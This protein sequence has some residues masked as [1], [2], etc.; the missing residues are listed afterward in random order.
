MQS[1]F[2]EAQLHQHN[3]KHH[4]SHKNKQTNNKRWSFCPAPRDSIERGSEVGN[5][6]THPNSSSNLWGRQRKTSPFNGRPVSFNIHLGDFESC[7]YLNQ[8]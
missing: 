8:F 5:L 3:E 1:P 7:E 4:I 6:T 2:Y